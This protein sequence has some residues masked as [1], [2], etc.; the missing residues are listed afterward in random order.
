MRLS[1]LKNSKVICLYSYSPNPLFHFLLSS[2]A[3]GHLELCNTS[4]IKCFRKANRGSNI[5]LLPISKMTFYMSTKSNHSRPLSKALTC[6]YQLFRLSKRPEQEGYNLP[7]GAG[8][9]RRERGVGCT[10]G[11]TLLQCPVDGIRGNVNETGLCRTGAAGVLPHK[12]HGHQAG[13]GCFR[14][15]N[16]AFRHAVFSGPCGRLGI[17]SVSCDI[18]KGSSALRLRRTGCPPQERDDLRFGAG[19]VR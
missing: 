13:A 4:K 3:S 7:S 2:H 12:F 6:Q 9:I 11:H 18:S 1:R 8:V 17:I 15:K 19:I 16:T 5:K 10:G 14:L